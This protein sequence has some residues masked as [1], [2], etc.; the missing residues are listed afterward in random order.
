MKAIRSMALCLEAFLPA[1]LL[2]GC[3]VGPKYEKPNVTVPEGFR[4]QIQ[5]PD[6]SSFADLPWWSVFNDKALQELINESLVNNNDIQV[7]VA[8]IEQAR[9]MVGVVQSEGKPQIG[10]EARAEGENAFVPQ[11]GGSVG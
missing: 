8:R 3:V 2:A 4:S 6:A 11:R 1:L 5:P 7:A 10:Y 9:A